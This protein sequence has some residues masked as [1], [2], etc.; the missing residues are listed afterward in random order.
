MPEGRIF[1][2]RLTEKAIRKSRSLRTAAVLPISP[3]GYPVLTVHQSG[4]VLV[5][6]VSFCIQRLIC[7]C[8][9]V[10]ILFICGHVDYFVGN[11]RIFRI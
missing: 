1:V 7:L 9:M 2:H 11:T 4:N 5:E 6:E 8:Y 10:I 3:P